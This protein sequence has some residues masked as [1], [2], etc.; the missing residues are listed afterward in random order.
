MIDAGDRRAGRRAHG[1][2]GRS[3]GARGVARSSRALRVALGQTA[4]LCGVE[5]HEYL[6]RAL[7]VAIEKP[8]A[9]YLPQTMAAQMSKKNT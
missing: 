4:R 6:R 5:P 9:V 7:R 8:G 3:S 1:S 2:G